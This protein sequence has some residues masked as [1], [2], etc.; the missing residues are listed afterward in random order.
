MALDLRAVREALKDIIRNGT[1]R[2]NLNVYAKWPDSPIIAPA[3]VIMPM[4]EYVAYHEAFAKGLGAAQ[5]QVRLYTTGNTAG[6][7]LLDELMSAGAGEANSVVD[8]IES[9]RTHASAPVPGL[10]WSDVKVD[11]GR[12]FGRITVESD[13]QTQFYAASLDVSVYLPRS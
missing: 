5:F 13:G 2:A 9:A 12:T 10:P 3:V 6:Q 7:D 4:P 8:A 1:E 11:R